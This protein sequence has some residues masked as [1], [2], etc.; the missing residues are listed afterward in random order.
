MSL[1]SFFYL[2]FSNIP[3]DG[4]YNVEMTIRTQ[5]PRT[6]F[7]NLP[8]HNLL[9]PYVF[10]PL[11][12]TMSLACRQSPGRLSRKHDALIVIDV[13]YD[14]LQWPTSSVA[15]HTKAVLLR[16]ID[17]GWTVEPVPSKEGFGNAMSNG[18]FSKI[19]GTGWTETSPKFVYGLSES[20]SSRSGDVPSQLTT[21]MINELLVS[22]D[23]E[24]HI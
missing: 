5:T 3:E 22:G 19:A 1:P 20:G 15:S 10:K 18:S 23:L 24:S 9:C 14:F 4:S 16:L 21:T 11:G 12:E 17:I 6:F 7:K 2:K 8:P 13:V